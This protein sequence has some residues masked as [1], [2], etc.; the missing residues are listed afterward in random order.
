[1]LMTQFCIPELRLLK[2]LSQN[3][4]TDF[5]SLQNSLIETKLLLNGN[6]TKIMLLTANKSVVSPTTISTLDGTVSEFVDTYEYMSIWL[7]R[8][9]NFKQHIEMLV[10]KFILTGFLV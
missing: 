9:L 1:M 5:I 6:K 2:L 10:K 3:L 8:N 4:Q 7:D